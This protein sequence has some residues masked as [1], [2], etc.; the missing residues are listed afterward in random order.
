MSRK[1]I[2]SLEE[3]DVSVSDSPE[4]EDAETAA[5]IAEDTAEVQETAGDIGST[6][7]AIGEAV[8]ESEELDNV[9]EVLQEGVDSGEG[10]TEETAAIA[11]VAVE[12]VCRRLGL[13]RRA[14][15]RKLISR[16]DFTSKHTRLVQTKIA[17]EE[18]KGRVAQAWEQF[19]AFLARM[20]EAIVEFFTSIKTKLEKIKDALKALSLDGKEYTSEKITEKKVISAFS[21]LKSIDGSTVP[22]FLEGLHG[23]IEGLTPSSTAIAEVAQKVADLTKDYSA[24]KAPQLSAEVN[25]VT[26]KVFKNLAN[27]G[28]ST[29]MKLIQIEKFGP[30]PGNKALTKSAVGPFTVINFMGTFNS[31]VPKEAAPL[32][33]DSA[34]SVKDRAFTLAAIALSY[35]EKTKNIKDNANAFNK[36]IDEMKRSTDASAED[37]KARNV[38]YSNAK[39]ALLNLSKIN[40]ALYSKMPNLAYIAAVASYSYI[41]SSFGSASEAE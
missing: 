17:L 9:A 22:D 35:A 32:D 15:Y 23:I 6:D 16:E 2:F 12:G 31:E 5:E 19:K 7:E 3:D 38:Q 4:L 36:A 13:T 34:A 33:A 28:K 37:N 40:G 25:Q 1:T 29:V 30:L 39:R 20:W 14:Q 24:E 11:E 10:V 27:A 26:E 8:N 21:G 41:Q 18:V